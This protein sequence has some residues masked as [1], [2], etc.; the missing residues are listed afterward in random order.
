VSAR[1]V[2]IRAVLLLFVAQG[3]GGG[4]GVQ[5]CDTSPQ[6]NPPATYTGG[7]VAD[8][9]YMS[10]PW[11]GPLLFFPG[12]M[13]YTLNHH[14]GEVPAWIQLYVAF[15]EDGAGGGGTIAEAAG[16]E[17]QIESVDSTAI[18]IA[19]L[20][21]AEYYLLVVAGRADRSTQARGAR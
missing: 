16:N 12:G 17:A 2:T 1:G 9:V 14:L 20:S 3:P 18:H 21:C 4:C 11:S 19:N 10:S 7:T 5:N 13:Q 8:Q 6:E 15:S